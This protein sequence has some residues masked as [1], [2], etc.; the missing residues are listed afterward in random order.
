MV[1]QQQG[2]DAIVIGSGIGGLTVAALLSK[3]H[4]KRVLVLEQHFTPGGFT[5]TFERKQKFQWDVGLHYIGGMGKGRT[6]K[7]VFDYLTDGNLRWHKMPEP[8]EKFVYPDFTFDVYGNPDRFQ[9][10]LIKRFPHEQTAIRRYFRDVQK[11]AFWFGAHSM[12]ELFPKGL[13]PLLRRMVRLWGVIA[14]QTTQHYL[15]RNFQDVRL[16]AVLASQ[17]GVVA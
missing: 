10:D 13:Q 1:A 14:R 8:F 9:S 11:A 4:R 12:L 6:G 3:L 2:F 15:N 17:W 16:K 5:H 7:A